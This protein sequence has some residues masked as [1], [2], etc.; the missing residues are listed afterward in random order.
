MPAFQKEKITQMHMHVLRPARLRSRR[1][2]VTN[3]NCLFVF[4]F[5]V[6]RTPR[7][8]LVCFSK[9]FELHVLNLFSFAPCFERPVLNNKGQERFERPDRD[10]SLVYPLC[11][12]PRSKHL[13]SRKRLERRVLHLMQR[14]E[15]PVLNVARS[16]TVLPEAS[17]P[18]NH[19]CSNILAA[20]L[21]SA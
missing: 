18:P 2:F 6:F 15:R 16:K 5:T 19:M 9:R 11:R 13:F 12:T 14:F 10:I 8:K 17:T 1:M 7:S 21:F 4:M 3:G 20:N